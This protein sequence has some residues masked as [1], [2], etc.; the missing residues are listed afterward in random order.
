M[1]QGILQ[2]HSN[3]EAPAACTIRQSNEQEAQSALLAEGLG[4]ECAM[5]QRMER[6]ISAMACQRGHFSAWAVSD[7][8]VLDTCGI[9][10]GTGLAIQ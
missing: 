5:L 4:L 7:E 8:H 6:R 10:I 3:G 9:Q 2:S 1:A